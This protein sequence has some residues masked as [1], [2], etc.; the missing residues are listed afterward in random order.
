M[1]IKKASG[2]VVNTKPLQYKALNKKI[3]KSKNIVEQLSGNTRLAVHY[4]HTG[5]EDHI[6]NV[7]TLVKTIYD[8]KTESIEIKEIFIKDEYEK[9]LSN[10]KL[11]FSIELTH[12]HKNELKHIEG[13][14][15]E[16]NGFIHSVALVPDPRHEQTNFQILDSTD[17]GDI[18]PEYKFVTNNNEVT[19]FNIIETIQGN[20][21]IMD[22][23]DKKQDIADS[24]DSKGSDVGFIKSTINYLTNILNKQESD[25]NKDI[26]DKNI[27]TDSLEK[28]TLKQDFESFAKSFESV[29]EKN[30]ELTDKTD[31]LE[32]KI[33]ALQD[34]MDRITAPSPTEIGAH[35]H[36]TSSIKEDT[37]KDSQENIFDTFFNKLK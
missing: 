37:I 36:T 27:V 11:G 6:P 23:T 19:S 26:N 25:I 32:I 18:S 5:T 7:G 29:I 21:T 12:T 30:K 31:S 4:K 15:Y 1:P 14:L 20:I 3:K 10:K 2:T 33:K 35:T 28:S 17:S 16:S 22:T 8:E 34:S 24:V 9:L 13:N